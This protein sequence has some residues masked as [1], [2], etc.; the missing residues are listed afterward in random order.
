ME[1]PERAKDDMTTIADQTVV[2]DGGIFKNTPFS[3]LH[4]RLPWR[5]PA[6]T[7]RGFL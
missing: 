1:P 5:H 4:H 7:P 2:L 3:Q 6:H